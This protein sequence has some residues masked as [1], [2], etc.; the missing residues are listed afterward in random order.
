L[1]KSL[2]GVNLVH[3]PYKGAALV[4]TDVIAGHVPLGFVLL[5]GALPHM[6]TGKLK[7]LAVTTEQRVNAARNLPT[8]A[9]AGV[10]GLVLF[11]WTGILVPAGTP[12]E[13]IS[14]LNQ[15]ISKAVRAPELHQ[16]WVEQGFEPR[17]GTS[18]EMA[19]LIKADINKWGRIIK[20]TGIGAE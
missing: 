2:A 14:R 20:Q 3:A 18:D 9:E 8:M 19:A 6:R 17:T 1:F 10:S 16:R 13:V 7:A 15:E 4:I 5:P 11:D 12:N